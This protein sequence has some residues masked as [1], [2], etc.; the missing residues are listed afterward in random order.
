[1]SRTVPSFGSCTICRGRAS[2]S[3]PAETRNDSC[4]EREHDGRAD[5]AVE[6]RRERRAD[7]DRAPAADADQAVRRRQRLRLDDERDDPAERG[8]EEAVAEPGEERQQSSSGNDR[9]PVASAT[10]SVP[11]TTNRARSDAII[12]SPARE[13]VG[14]RAADQQRRQQADSLAH[15]DDPEPLRADERERA[16]AERREE[17]GVA[18]RETTWPVQSRRKSRDAAR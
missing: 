2:Q 5:G 12:I 10:A 7:Q 6:Q 16:P 11:T 14:E 15:E 1:M 8:E 17:R 4:V 3:R 9:C 13:P 18:D